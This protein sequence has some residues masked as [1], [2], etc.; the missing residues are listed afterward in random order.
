MKQKD[1]NLPEMK[2]KYVAYFILI[3]YNVYIKIFTNY[4]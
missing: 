4:K 3:F 2:R 1:F